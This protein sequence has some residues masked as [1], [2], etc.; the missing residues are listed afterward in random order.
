VYLIPANSAYHWT[1]IGD[2]IPNLPG[3]NPWEALNQ[4]A[5]AVDALTLDQYHDICYWDLLQCRNFNCSASTTVNLDAIIVRPSGNRLEDSVEIAL[6][7]DAEIFPGH[8][9]T[10]EG[11]TGEVMEGGWTWYYDLILAAQ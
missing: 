8:W 5:I 7:P 3:I 9:R 11:A 1:V 4:E 10:P 6:L 2:R